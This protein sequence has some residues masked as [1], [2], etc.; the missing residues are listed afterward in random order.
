[1]NAQLKTAPVIEPISLIEL[2]EHLA[3]D[4][5]A[6]VDNVAVTQSIVPG[7][8]G[9]HELMTLDVAPG[10]AGWAAGDT[11][12]G[13][14]SNQT[15]VVVSVLTTK[16]YYVR[17][18]S[19]AF[20]LGEVLSNGVATADQGAAHPTFAT[21]YYLIGAAAE[22]LGY[23]ALVRLNAGTNLATG[24]VD[25]KIQDSDDGTTW[26]DWVGGAF[27]Q[28]T[29][30]N[31]NA[32]Y[33]KA[34]TGEKRYIRVLGQVLLAAC[35]FSV[36]I[37]TLS[38]VVSQDDYLNDLIAE[39]RQFI[40]DQTGRKLLT[41]TW[42]YYPPCWPDGDRLRIPFGNLQTVT[43]ITYKDCDGTVTTM[44]VTTEYLVETNGDQHGYIVL[45]YG[46]SWPS[47]ALWPSKPITIEFVCGWTSQALISRNIR[48]MMKLYCTYAYEH[49]GEMITGQAMEDKRFDRLRYLESLWGEVL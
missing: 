12:T 38:P 19:G 10:G 41:Q 15:C 35:S 42:Y 30:A 43:A 44:T 6:F 20:T 25:I 22:V 27:T 17:D 24:T 31:D 34:Y 18:R 4:S 39:A 11:I 8:H 7:S 45:P 5:G 28:V 36:D 33:E 23:S 47:A 29:T 16:T 26:A 21:G 13:Q 2:K 9:I 37:E 3:L 40:E 49:K 1:M 46:Q 48:A 32:V 14:S